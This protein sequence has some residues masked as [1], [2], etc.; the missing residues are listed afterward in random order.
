MIEIKKFIKLSTPFI[1]IIITQNSLKMLYFHFTL[2]LSLP[3]DQNFSKLKKI[4][5]NKYKILSHFS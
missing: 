4:L 3:N 5:D 2:C 1:H